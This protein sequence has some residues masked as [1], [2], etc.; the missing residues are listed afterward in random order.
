MF[1]ETLKETIKLLIVL[2]LK[3]ITY[4]VE[5]SIKSDIEEKDIMIS[6]Y[7]L[8]IKV[9]PKATA[10]DIN[11]L[12]EVLEINDKDYLVMLFSGAFSRGFN[13]R[14]YTEDQ[15]S[16]VLEKLKTIPVVST[17]VVYMIKPRRDL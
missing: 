7:K 11:K 15:V 12:S 6:D 3:R 14:G 9:D 13:K 1:F 5:K 8:Y 4:K 16:D 17:N 2:L 10:E